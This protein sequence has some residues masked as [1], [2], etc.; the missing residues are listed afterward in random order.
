M[1]VT[2][3]SGSGAVLPVVG[4]GAGVGAD[5]AV[6]GSAADVWREAASGRARK[7]AFGSC[8]V[9]RRRLHRPP[10]VRHFHW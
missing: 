3:M 8:M 5:G 4:L 2:V 7:R 9:W 6:T 10:V 1:A